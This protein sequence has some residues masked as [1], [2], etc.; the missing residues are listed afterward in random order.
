[1]FKLVMINYCYRLVITFLPLTIILKQRYCKRFPKPLNYFKRS[2]KKGNYVVCTYLRVN[3]LS[4]LIL[5]LVKIV[6]VLSRLLP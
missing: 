5:I 2:R 6:D 4:K 3:S 1:M